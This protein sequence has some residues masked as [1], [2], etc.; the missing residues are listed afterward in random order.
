MMQTSGSTEVWGRCEFRARSLLIQ[1]V[2]EHNHPASFDRTT[3]VP[4][5]P[6]TC[7]GEG[8]QIKGESTE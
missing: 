3:Q 4:E 8:S 7:Y 6:S 1:S 2:I 5:R